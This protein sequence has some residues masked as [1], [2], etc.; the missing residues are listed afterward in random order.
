M[1]EPLEPHDGQRH[2]PSFSLT[3][4]LQRVLWGVT[5]F[6]LCRF[7]PPPFWAWRRFV[8]RLFGARIGA[9]ARVYGSVKIWLPA[10]LELGDGVLIGRE[11]NCYNQGRIT[12]DRDVVVSQNASLCASTHDINDP[13]FPLL[14]RPIRI[15]AHA[16]IAAEAFVGPGVTVGEGAVLGARGVAMRDLE[17]WAFHSGNPAVM[18]KPRRRPDR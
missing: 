8:L 9:G 15:R 14:V 7:T 4:K 13:S 17:E 1:T 12:I 16:W 3:N 18:L 6:A 5:W 10:N 11:V 2:S